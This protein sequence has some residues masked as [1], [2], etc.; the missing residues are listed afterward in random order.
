ML[1]NHVVKT[2]S[3]TQAIISVSSGEAEFYAMV[4]GGSSGR[5]FQA[6]LKELGITL[7]L[8]IKTDASAAVGISM[9]RG[10][11]KVRHIDVSQLWIR[12]KVASGEIRIIKV[13][14]QENISDA[15]T[16]HVSSKDLG[17]HVDQTYQRRLSGGAAIQS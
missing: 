5:G 2:W 13:R 11:G 16:K 3:S 8:I 14:S 17:W 7:P 9:R 15:L 6:T 10:L 4:K 1:G 12:E